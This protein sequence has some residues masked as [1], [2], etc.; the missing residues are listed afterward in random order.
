MHFTIRVEWQREDGTTATAE[1]VTADHGPCESAGDVGLK[2]VAAKRIVARLQETV[3]KKQLEQY[4]EAART[5]SVCGQRRL[6]KDNRQR[7]FY[8]VFGK[9]TVKAPRFHGCRF[10]QDQACISPLSKLLEDRVSPELRYLQAKFAA[11][12]PYRSGR[13]SAARV[14]TGNWRSESRHHPQPHPSHR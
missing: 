2:L 8:T 4:C 6:L 5:C 14:V 11:Q 9:I 3:V 13:R 10:C 12:L 7:R 1:L